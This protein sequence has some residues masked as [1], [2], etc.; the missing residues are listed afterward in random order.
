MNI[1]E[2]VGK[3]ILGKTTRS[4]YPRDAEISEY[5]VI[6][7]S[8]SGNWVKLQNLYGSKFWK[9]VTD[10]SYVEELHDLKPGGPVG[11]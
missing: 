4:T 5:R 2:L 9:P 10:V 8:P 1:R 6:E 7:V 11:A 3:R